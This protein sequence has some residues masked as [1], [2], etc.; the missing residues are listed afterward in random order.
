MKAVGPPPGTV[1]PAY[2]RSTD[3]P[4]RITQD[5][6]N[7]RP[8]R[9]PGDRTCP[10]CWAPRRPRRRTAAGDG[11]VGAEG[12]RSVHAPGCAPFGDAA[13]RAG[14]APGAE[15]ARRRARH[16]I[17][18]RARTASG[19]GTNLS[20]GSEGR[21]AHGVTHCPTFVQSACPMRPDARYF[22]VR[23]QGAAVQSR[24][25]KR[26]P[27]FPRYAW[28]RPEG[29]I[30]EGRY[31]CVPAFGIQVAGTGFEPATSGL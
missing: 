18:G 5:A 17:G 3:G 24:N 19:R 12:R 6:P 9:A 20:F 31:A 21:A 27:G 29:E 7:R 8:R 28:P 4:T 16:Q 14:T 30:T 22:Q 11:E 2:T 25:G 10:G 1:R 13:Y 23:T 15:R 26:Q